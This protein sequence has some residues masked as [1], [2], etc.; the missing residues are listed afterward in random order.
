[1]ISTNKDTLLNAARRICSL[2]NNFGAILLPM[3]IFFLF[4][5][6]LFIVFTFQLTFNSHLPFYILIHHNMIV[7]IPSAGIYRG[8]HT[9]MH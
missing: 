3:P 5:F 2:L 4:L 7:V 9:Y 6:I 8:I 1:M